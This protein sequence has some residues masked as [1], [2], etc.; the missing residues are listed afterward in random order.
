MTKT[1]IDCKFAVFQDYGYSN[2]TT[3]GTTFECRKSAHPDGN[4]DRFYGK[5]E[6]LA[7]AGKCPQFSEGASI[8]MDCDGENEAN[9]TPE[10]KEIYHGRI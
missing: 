10:Q 3:E 8:E 1:C 2:Y 6:R 7:Y 5:D 9:L 4:F